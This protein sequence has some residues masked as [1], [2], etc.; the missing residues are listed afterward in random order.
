MNWIDKKYKELLGTRSYPES[1]K[2]RGWE[3]AQAILDDQFPLQQSRSTT[4]AWRLGLGVVLLVGAMGTALWYY[5]ASEASESPL[6]YSPRQHAV[7]IP[8]PEK[9]NKVSDRNTKLEKQ[10]R[11]SVSNSVASVHHVREGGDASGNTATGLASRRHKVHATEIAAPE[12]TEKA[13]LKEDQ[14]RE[15]SSIA[16][17]ASVP[18][19]I[20]EKTYAEGVEAKPQEQPQTVVKTLVTATEEQPA[21]RTEFAE[22]PNIQEDVAEKAAPVPTA[23][24]E[25]ANSPAESPAF[26]AQNQTKD[27]V[28]EPEQG[29]TNED[30]P[31]AMPK[32]GDSLS[33]AA[34]EENPSA[35][36]NVALEDWHLAF[37][38]TE[39]TADINIPTL[40]GRRFS[41]SVFAGYHY[42]GKKLSG[43]AERYQQKRQDEELPI[44]AT[45]T[46]MDLTYYLDGRWTFGTGF[47]YAGYGEQLQYDI[48]ST[49]TVHLD[50]RYFNPR[51]YRSNLVGLD[52]V[53]VVDSIY[54]GHWDYRAMYETQ[55]T[56]ARANNG[57]T[58]L[59][60]L[61]I[62]LLVGYRF[63]GGIVKPWLR[64]GVSLGLPVYTSFRYLDASA[65]ALAESGSSQL[66]VAPVQW[67][68]LM[69]MGLDCKLSRH[70]SLQLNATGSLQLK[71]VLQQSVASQ[72]YYRVGGN[73]GLSYNF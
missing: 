22:E 13:S 20:A 52:S 49:D 6:H 59:T 66:E 40:A 51:T 8:R 38:K 7:D 36:K 5:A 1:M 62:P 11:A 2:H 43:G 55:D 54:K 14:E 34:A 16:A 26:T 42:V 10:D 46:G 68:F 35:A 45:A 33:V 70:F 64:S 24:A 61:E 58:N 19:E 29:A 3:K 72:R 27:P 71:S 9:T 21:N 18:A 48:R 12:T 4:K 44:W 50:G 65:L 47:T 32:A 15:H 67:S 37:P 28:E 53:R 30:E 57:R 23:F 41:I 60:Y 17:S 73:L 25:N 31:A 69:Q 63:R 39:S 56:A